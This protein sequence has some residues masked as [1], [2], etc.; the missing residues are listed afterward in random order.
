MDTLN[1]HLKAGLCAG[2]NKSST[3]N[4]LKMYLFL[5][6]VYVLACLYVQVPKEARR[7]LSSFSSP[8]PITSS[9]LPAK[10]SSASPPNARILYSAIDHEL[11]SVPTF[12]MNHQVAYQP[13]GLST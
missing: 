12:D 11:A 5:F 13:P 6:H 3:A 7:R 10:P 2:E 9:V 4:P 8:D 1:H